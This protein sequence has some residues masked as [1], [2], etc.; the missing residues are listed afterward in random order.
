MP[1]LDDERPV[2]DNQIS[3]LPKGARAEAMIPCEAHRRQ[4]ELAVLPVAAYVDVQT[5]VAVKAVEIEPIGPWNPRDSRHPRLFLE[6]GWRASSMPARRP[7]RFRENGM[8]FEEIAS[9][10]KNGI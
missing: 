6:G 9:L 7:R 2:L 10:R 4:P 1:R 8:P 3:D 5:L